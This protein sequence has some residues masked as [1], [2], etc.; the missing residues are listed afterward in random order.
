M[1]S[2]EELRANVAFNFLNRYVPMA[3]DY[4]L[5]CRENAAPKSVIARARVNRDLVLVLD[6]SLFLVRSLIWA[7][8]H[9]LDV[10]SRSE[11]AV[12]SQLDGLA[13]RLVCDASYVADRLSA[14]NRMDPSKRPSIA[15]V[16]NSV[17]EHSLLAGGI[18]F[19]PD[20]PA[21]VAVPRV[22][23]TLVRLCRAKTRCYR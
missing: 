9:S 11:L 16:G 23:S 5:H 2:E 18:Q 22:L 14:I 13:D 6:A 21:A 20:G 8:Q 15:I 17:S 3:W 10:N 19:G 7:W 4:F 12:R 1:T